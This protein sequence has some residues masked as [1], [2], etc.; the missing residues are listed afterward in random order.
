MESQK[1]IKLYVYVDGVNDVPFYGSD[2]GDYEEF[3]LSN[4][5]R[6]VTKDG[7]VFNVRNTNEQIEL[8]SFR[9][10]AKRM[11][12][13]PTISFTLMYEDCLDDFWSDNVYALF[14]GE[15]YFLKQTPTSSKSNEDARY[16]HDVELISARAILDNV[17]FY[18]AVVGDPQGEDKPVSNSTKFVFFGKIDEFARRLNASLQ[19]A[20]L[21]KVDEY[22]EYESGYRV[23]VDNGITSEAMFV[24]FEDQYFSNA[25]QESYNTFKVP[26]YFVGEDIHFGNSNG[27]IE[28]E[29]SYGIDDALLSITKSNANNKIVNRVTGKG[30]SENI[31]YYYPN[32]SAKGIVEAVPS[33]GFEVKILDYEKFAEAI[34][35][36]GILRKSGVGYENALVTFN[37]ESIFSGKTF[38]ARM[39]AG[40]IKQYFNVSFTSKDVGIFLLNF[41]SSV[42]KYLLQEEE[43]EDATIGVVYSFTVYDDTDKKWIQESKGLLDAIDNLEVQ[44]PYANHKYIISITCYYAAEGKYA[45]KGG[46]IVF[47]ASYS[48]GSKSGWVYEDKVI[49]LKDAGLVIEGEA[50]VGSTITQKSTSKITNSN[51]LMPPIYRNSYGS[52]RFYNAINYPYPKPSNF[53][54]TLENG[55]YGEDGILRNPYGEYEV[56]GYIHN[57]AYKKEDGT[58]IHFDNPFVEGQPKEHIISVDDIKPTIK[59]AVN[60]SG[61]RLDMFTAFAYDD[62]D[63]DET[64]VDNNGETFYEHPY[65]F[66]KLRVL[67]FNLFEC[68]NENQP[69]TISFTSG[70]CGAC[71]FEIGATEDYP[72]LNPVQVTGEGELIYKDGRVWCGLEG[73]EGQKVDEY[74]P[75][76][77]DTS[78]YEVWIALKKEEETYGALMPTENIRPQACSSAMANDGDTFVILGINLP[79]EYITRQ[80]RQLE[81]EIIKYIKDNNDE[82]FNFSITLSRIFFAENPTI[83]EQLNENASLYVWY[84]GVRY[85]LYVSSISYN[86]GEGDVLPEVRLELVDSLSVSQ[87]AIQAAISQVKAQ[88]G[89]ALA[90]LDVLTAVSPFFIRKDIDDEVNTVTNFKKGIKFG[91]GGKIEVMDNNSA[92]LTIEYLEVTKKATFTSLEIQEKTHVGGQILVSPAAMTCGEVEELENAYRCYFQTKGEDGEEIFNQFAVGDQAICQTYNAWGSRY[93]WRLVTG[94]G[95]DYIDLSKTDCDNDSDVPMAGD[96]IIQLGHRTDKSR[97]SAI[98]I[99]SYGETSPSLIMYK[100]IKSY[101]LDNNEVTGILWNPATQEPQMYSY[102]SFFFGDNEK[103]ENGEL[104]GDFITFQPSKDDPTGEKKLYINANVTLG[105]ESKGLSDLSEWT[106]FKSEIEGDYAHL[107]G[108]FEQLQDQIDGVVE[109]YFLEGDPSVNKAPV[110]EWTTDEDK[111]NHVGDTYTNIEEFIDETTT[112]NAGKSWRWCEC[113]SYPIETEATTSVTINSTPS[114]Q[115]IGNVP[116]KDYGSAILYRNGS[117]LAYFCDFDYDKEI[118]VSSG[119][120]CRIRVERATGDVYLDNYASSIS[121]IVYI[122][123]NVGVVMALKNGNTLVKL[124]W[125]PIADT[126]ALKAL[127]EAMK[128]KEIADGKS[129]TFIVQPFPPY[130]EGDLWVQGASGDILRCKAGVN[131]ENGG[132]YDAND[133]EKATKYT[134]DTKANEVLSKLNQ[135]VDDLNQSILDAESA[136]KGYTDEAKSNLEKTIDDINTTKANIAD[137]YTKAEA[138]GKIDEKEQ[139]ILAQAEEVAKAQAA[140]LDTQ[141]KAYADGEISKA[142]ADA[143]AEAQKRVDAAK[144]DLEKAIAL[145]VKNLV[146]NSSTIKNYMLPLADYSDGESSTYYAKILLPIK[147]NGG[148]TYTFKCENAQKLSGSQT[149]YRIRIDDGTRGESGV[150]NVFSAHLDVP[151]GDNQSVTFTIFDGV[152]DKVAFLTIIRQKPSSTIVNSKSDSILLNN[153]SLVRGAT[154]M[155]AWEDYKGD[156]GLNNLLLIPEEVRD[157]SYNASWFYVENLP[158]TVKGG[159][160]YAISVDNLEKTGG[161]KDNCFAVICPQDS[162]EWLSDAVYISF[163]RK[164]WG[165]FRI[166][167]DVVSSTARLMIGKGEADNNLKLNITGL[168]LVRGPLPLMEWK[169]NRAFL[170]TSIANDYGYLRDTFGQ[171]TSGDVFLSK[172]MGVGIKNEGEEDFTVNAFM[173][174]SDEIKTEEDGKLMIATGIPATGGTLAQRA[175]QATTRIYEKGKIETNELNAKGGYIGGVKITEEGLELPQT[176]GTLKIGSDGF[177]F[178]NNSGNGPFIDLDGCDNG[179]G[180]FRLDNS[181]GAPAVKYCKDGDRVALMVATDNGSSAFECPRGMFGGLR[182]KLNIVSEQY[183]TALDTDHTLYVATAT[184]ITLPSSPMRGQFYKIIKSK[185]LGGVQLWGSRFLNLVTGQSLS[186]YL[187]IPQNA[188]T[189]EVTYINASTPFW[190]VDYIAH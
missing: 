179:G 20:K 182:P 69:M 128:A 18:D 62:D 171:I 9:Y 11:G 140:L 157:S 108:L 149:C 98:V 77:Q 114:V 125:H 16:R 88:M 95:Q 183:Y 180:L 111:L 27:V 121:A 10:D 134:D 13:A 53:D 116:I 35:I 91:E 60:A 73:V 82:K 5:E 21:Q 32:N 124:H 152:V 119:P 137:V 145:N 90:N 115:K 131:K 185:S 51:F 31:P 55:Y 173:N 87:N 167:D 72:Q 63:N 122:A 113:S 25:I 58:Y 2:A 142:E 105:K 14:N 146:P 26:Y 24:S 123:F 93:F 178:S 66:G 30:S 175:A 57:D 29:F 85:P 44:V 161:T 168:S 130:S 79:E 38:S 33:S 97:Q 68:A 110:T 75:R 47:D 71:N 126:D 162:S 165:I 49:E 143:I 164:T 92:K 83:L 154:P 40:G 54:E 184:S 136:M 89:N 127:Q 148:E 45:G 76:Q 99:S 109:N 144:T 103:D 150:T 17:L 61:L 94:V 8:G 1:T 120:P 141:V 159:E 117:P 23:I 65:F 78:K 151:F 3:I 139:E 186:S 132:S 48:F 101:S 187:E 190:A 106:D 170:A 155:S 80:E 46:N 34:A 104:I 174:G 177:N 102:G 81:K 135:S 172:L 153:V 74:Q 28:H 15:K 96:K 42:I 7:F 189:I 19:Y 52:E 22:G 129:R 176:H 37:N 6:F 100:D 39:G 156:A 86:I 112:P 41:S 188:T 43:K 107:E 166:K 160:T 181:S 118:D 50:I 84:N 158:F 12:G 36:D 138:D 67:D 56:E 59:E 163:K 70:N 169:E 133:W 147:V 64:Y 4:G